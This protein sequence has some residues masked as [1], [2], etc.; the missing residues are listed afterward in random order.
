MTNTKR[1]NVVCVNPFI[2]HQTVAH[3]KILPK[4]K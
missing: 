3:L 1:T 2:K 4:L